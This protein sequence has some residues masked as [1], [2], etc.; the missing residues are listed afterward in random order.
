[1]KR[2]S[3]RGIHNNITIY[4]NTLKSFEAVLKSEYDGIEADIRLINDGNIIVYHDATLNRLFNIDKKIDE[5]SYPELNKISN[6]ILLLEDLLLFIKKNNFNCILDI[7]NN[8]FLVIETLITFCNIYKVN[9][10]KITL[11]SWKLKINRYN[12]FKI[13]YATEKEE[14][15]ESEILNIK[16]YKFDGICLAFTNN[17]DNTI[18]RIYKHKLKLTYILQDII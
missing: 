9:K 4:E 3:H 10:N 5:C 8:D 16:N 1:M 2:Y 11:L 17:N 6:K 12:L 13:Y 15:S 14:L 7:K 18:K